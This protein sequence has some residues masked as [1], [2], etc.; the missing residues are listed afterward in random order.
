MSKIAKRER[1]KQGK[2]T[3]QSVEPIGA[4][5][6]T[7][8]AEEQVAHY[9]VGLDVGM[10]H[11]Q[12]CIINDAGKVIRE[13]EVSSKPAA[14]E[15][16]IR[17]YGL[18]NI[19]R[20]VVESGNL[21]GWLYQELKRRGLPITCVD[22]L[23]VSRFLSVKRNKT[24]VNDARGLAEIA[25]HGLEFVSAVHVKSA[26]CYE[27]RGLISFVAGSSS[28]GSKNELMLRGMLKAYGAIIETTGDSD[29]FRSKVIDAMALIV[30][31]DKIDLRP[32]FMPILDLIDDL[33]RRADRMEEDLRKLAEEQP[34]CKRFME[35]PGVG[36]IVALSFF[37]AIEDPRRFR[38]SE[39]VGAYL[40]LTPRVYQSGETDTKGGISHM[41]S[42][43]TRTH[44]V[45]AANCILSGTKSFSSLKAWGMKLVKR[46]GYNKAKVAVA[47][48]LATL[49]FAMWRDNKSF[50]Y[51]QEALQASL[52]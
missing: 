18:S 32:R 34:I 16:L 6:V 48:K 21:S 22:A 13:K 52:T 9:Y 14:L 44:L 24:D 7:E 36:P 2:A 28:S 30:D 46:V 51:S 20:V 43:M 42:V 41:G 37:T 47:R 25:R 11:T 33:R 27:I 35:I 26:G 23:Q 3:K 45:N 49:M 12:V 15:G 40:G 39:D 5:I 29:T 4:D 1:V 50:Y 38:R 8:V 19:E 10:K 31:R 17:H